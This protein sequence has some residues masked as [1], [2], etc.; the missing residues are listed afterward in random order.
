MAR[1]L[2]ECIIAGVPTTIPFLQEVMADPVFRAGEVYTDYI[3]LSAIS[4][5]QSA[6]SS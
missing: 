1:A 3:E 5:Q 2:H 6:L 4:R